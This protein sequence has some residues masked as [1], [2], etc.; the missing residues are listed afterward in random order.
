M[1]NPLVVVVIVVVAIAA[2]V[3]LVRA[4]NRSE[5]NART[6]TLQPDTTGTSLS[7]ADVT[8]L[9]MAAQAGQA[10]IELA[11]LAERTSDHASVDALADRLERDHSAANEQIEDLADEKHVDFPNDAMGL[12]GPTDQQKAI[13][14]SLAELKGAAF[15]RAWIDRIVEGHQASVDLF[16]RASAS[17]DPDVKSFAERTLPTLREHLQHAQDLQKTLASAR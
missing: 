10:E 3:M 8:F 1:K 6:E 7:A 5:D 4:G 11:E 14:D 16:S 17:S 9:T 15:N 2:A 13:R 12:P